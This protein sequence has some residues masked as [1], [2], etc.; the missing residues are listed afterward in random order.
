MRILFVAVACL[1]VGVALGWQGQVHAAARD[2]EVV[3]KLGD[4][5][6]M[7]AVGE[8]CSLGR[9]ISGIPLAVCTPIQPKVGQYTIE[10]ARR[11]I[12]ITKEPP[13]K[14]SGVVLSVSQPTRPK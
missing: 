9:Q 2:K 13:R 11:S 3:I 5:A 1:S 6:V 7:P 4:S 12:E 10:I 8:V 14:G